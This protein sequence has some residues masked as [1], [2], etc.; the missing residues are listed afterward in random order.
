MKT[1]CLTYQQAGTLRDQFSILLA[2][3]KAKADTAS[4]TIEE[5]LVAP[6]DMLNKWFF[7]NYYMECR[8]NE[9]AL[10][11]YQYPAYHVIAVIRQQHEDGELTY[12]YRDLDVILQ[13]NMITFTKPFV[14]ETMA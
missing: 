7:F 3:I 1:T 13:D 10:Q 2:Q 9:A 6:A 4:E 14:Y 11:F 8:D 5:L 12:S